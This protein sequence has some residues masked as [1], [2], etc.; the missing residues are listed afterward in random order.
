MP[1]NQ[2]P[3]ALVYAE[4]DALPIEDAAL[5]A[6]RL[7]DVRRRNIPGPPR[8]RPS[9]AA[10]AQYDAIAVKDPE[11]LYLIVGEKQHAERHFYS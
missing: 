4:G 8:L 11:T 6:D 2:L 7:G 5:N 9:G 10:Q 1:A 3:D